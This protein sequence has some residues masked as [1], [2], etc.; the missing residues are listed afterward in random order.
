MHS[1]HILL[2]S[3]LGKE[4][5]IEFLLISLSSREFDRN[6]TKRTEEDPR[7]LY[8]NI[9]RIDRSRTQIRNSIILTFLINLQLRKICSKIKYSQIFLPIQKCWATISAFLLFLYN[10]SSTLSVH[11]EKQ[12]TLKRRLPHSLINTISRS[13]YE[14]SWQMDPSIDIASP[15][16]DRQGNSAGYFANFQVNNRE[17]INLP[18][19][20]S[21]GNNLVDSSTSFANIK[22]IC[23]DY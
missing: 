15:S 13:T 23:R 4:I 17:L 9:R 10:I 16:R 11:S 2:P 6:G 18:F 22:E 8:E 19:E 12:K 14:V 3:P 1:S 5:Q 20:I 21:L 7:F